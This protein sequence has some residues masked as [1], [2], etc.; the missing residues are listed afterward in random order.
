MNLLLYLILH[1]SF[2]ID[3]V[4]FRLHLGKAQ[5]SLAL[6]SVCTKILHLTLLSFKFYTVNNRP[7]QRH[8]V[9][10]FQFVAY[11]YAASND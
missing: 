4:D 3:F 11:A 5:A 8:L 6:H 7:P 10:V 9:G 2:F 1:F